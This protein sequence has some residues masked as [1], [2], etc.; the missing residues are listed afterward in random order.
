MKNITI[1]GGGNIGTLLAANL[2]SKPQF[3]VKLLTSNTTKWQKDLEVYDADDN[4]IRTGKL[5]GVYSDAKEAF[6]D[7]DII[8][9]TLPSNIYHD[10]IKE[11]LP[12]IDSKTYFGVL[13]GMGGK[14]FPFYQNQYSKLK[15]FAFQRVP[16][17]ARIKEYGKSVYD[18]GQRDLLHYATKNINKSENLKLKLNFEE[19]FG[20]KCMQLDNLLNVTLTPSNPILHTSRLYG[21]SKLQVNG[22]FEEKPLFYNDWDRYS[23]EILLGMDTEVQ[24]I[25]N[26]IEGLNLSNV[27]SLTSHYEATTADQLTNKLRS[28]KSLS[29]IESPMIKNNDSWI[30]DYNS[31]YFTEDFT[32]GLCIIKSFSHIL[33]LSSPNIDIV[34]KWYQNIS[35]QEFYKKGIYVGD[36]LLDLPLPQNFGIL[37]LTDIIDFYCF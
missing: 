29:N 36:S 23:S 34:L 21:L 30:F 35:N 1:I 27:R 6:K 13:P 4:L 31:R 28:I 9:C 2:S 22:V 37:N 5:T 24:D 18:L 11:Y 33:N 20:I 25:C 7:A 12:F 19:I 8:F 26:S 16:G 17:V 3:E 14:E 15:Y 32:Y 10:K